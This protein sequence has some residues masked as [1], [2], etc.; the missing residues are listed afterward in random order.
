MEIHSERLRLCGGSNLRE[1]LCE[2]EGGG[3]GGGGEREREKKGE[4]TH[5]HML[6]FYVDLYHVV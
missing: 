5:I 6:A 3:G 2:K 4:Q 1:C